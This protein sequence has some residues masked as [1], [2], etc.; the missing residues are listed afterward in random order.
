M[1]ISIKTLPVTSSHFDGTLEY[2]AHNLYGLYQCKATAEALRTIR[3]KRHF[4][5]T[6]CVAFP[7]CLPSVTIYLKPCGERRRFMC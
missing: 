3:Q 4:I 1:N 5:F 2:E 6:R 7:V